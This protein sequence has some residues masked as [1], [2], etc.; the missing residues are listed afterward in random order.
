VT[1]RIHDDANDCGLDKCPLAYCAYACSEAGHC[2]S[3]Y[4]E[5]TRSPAELREKGLHYLQ[6]AHEYMSVADRREKRTAHNT[7]RA[8]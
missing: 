8:P 1:Y 2:K 3:L 7:G 4:H 5:A 6:L